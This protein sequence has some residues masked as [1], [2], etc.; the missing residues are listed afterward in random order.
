MT[1]Q[2]ID[3]DDD[4]DD[5]DNEDNAIITSAQTT[6]RPIQDYT[7]PD[8]RIQNIYLTYL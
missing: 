4:D 7:Q 2:N 1:T 3:D 5:D 8:G 6:F